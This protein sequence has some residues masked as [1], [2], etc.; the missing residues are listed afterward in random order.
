MQGTKCPP[1]LGSPH[2]LQKVG[3]KGK[4]FFDYISKK[5]PPGPWER[6]SQVI[7]TGKKLLTVFY[8]PKKK[9]KNLQSQIF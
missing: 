8:T 1:K 6:K 3:D 2:F 9:R 5:W 7:K 4:I